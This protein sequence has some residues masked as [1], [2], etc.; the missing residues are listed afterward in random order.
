MITGFVDSEGFEVFDGQWYQVSHFKLASFGITPAQGQA[1]MDSVCGHINAVREAGAQ[2]GVG[3][4]LLRDHDKSKFGLEEFAH[5]ARQYH[6]DRGDM[7]GYCQAWLHHIHTNEHHWQH[8]I[9]PDGYAPS[10]SDSEAGVIS[11]PERYALEMVADWMGAS[12]QYTGSWDIGDWLTKNMPKIR[13]HSSTA[14][15]LREV[16][17]GL[18]YNFVYRLDFLGE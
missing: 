2:L 3:K 18:G 1:F 13:L 5:Y 6:G 4:D 12:K 9:F 15:Y 11:M 17:G 10:G 8:W 7:P 14:A 16:L